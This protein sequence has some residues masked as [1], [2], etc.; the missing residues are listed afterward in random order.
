MTMVPYCMIQSF[1]GIDCST[2]PSWLE[3]RQ[4]QTSLW[5]LHNGFC[6]SRLTLQTNIQTVSSELY[7]YFFVYMH[8]SL[9]SVNEGIIFLFCLSAACVVC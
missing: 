6:L 9:N 2:I 5:C 4:T 1:C 7:L 3:C 8:S